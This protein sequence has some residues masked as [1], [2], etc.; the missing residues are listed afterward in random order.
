MNEEKLLIFETRA[1]LCPR[2]EL[3][4]FARQL[5]AEL[6]G[7]RPFCALVTTDAR[8]QAL[9]RE[10]RGLDASTDVLS[11]PSGDAA[12]SL[13]DIAISIGHARRQAREHGHDAATEIRVLL[14]HGLLHLLGHDHESDRGQMRRLETR[15]R[16][17]YA[18]P[19]GLIERT[20]T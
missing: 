15:L 6:A 17:R 20:R 3:E 5:S 19:A 13:G 8:L 9:N 16:R 2:R 1:R 4:A 12:G 14:L 18:L 11:F 7:A 10:F